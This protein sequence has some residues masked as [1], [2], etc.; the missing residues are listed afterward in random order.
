MPNPRILIINSCGKAKSVKHYNQPTCADLQ[1]QEQR[2]AAVNKFA[3]FLR[4]A[5]DLYIGPQARAVKEAVGILSKSHE[6]VYY[7]IS[8]GFGLV[9]ADTLLPPYECSFSGLGKKEILER[10]MQLDIP[11]KI[12]ELLV[13]S[14]HFDIIFL[15]LGKD[16]IT[17][18]GNLT[19]FTAFADKIIIFTHIKDINSRKF[20]IY[21]P[22]LFV[23]N[24]L[25]KQIFDVP[26]GPTV[27]AKGTILLNYAK[28]LVHRGQTV[29]EYTFS[30]WWNEKEAKLSETKGKL[31]EISPTAAVTASVESFLY[32]KKVNNFI[33]SKPYNRRDDY[34]VSEGAS[35]FI[36]KRMA[37]KFSD[38]EVKELWER[39]KN[40]RSINT[41]SGESRRAYVNLYKDSHSFFKKVRDKV[42]EITNETKEKYPEDSLSNIRGEIAN[43]LRI[44]QEKLGYENRLFNAVKYAM[45]KS[46]VGM[47]EDPRKLDMPVVYKPRKAKG[48]KK[49]A[50]LIKQEEID[51]VIESKTKKSDSWEVLAIVENRTHYPLQNIRIELLDKKGKTIP[52]TAA[53]GRLVELAQ[54]KIFIPIVEAPMDDE[55]S[56]TRILFRTSIVEPLDKGAIARIELDD[57]VNKE[58]VD[59]EFEI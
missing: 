15:T 41:R 37:E 23:E 19:V 28:S 1:T 16:Y 46:L 25:S 5:K 33:N 17:A 6:V 38:A 51:L 26:I 21:N 8:A 30:Q 42:E 57:T 48:E 29:I 53:S 34:M 22:Q 56:E 43:Q 4:P 45:L 10:A 18:L 47:V 58:S 20:E 31:H 11:N 7:I 39:C 55:V 32:E 36:S 44:R 35:K 24:P 40:L 27:G 50:P 49:K 9:H 13:S 54:G 12:K 52:I 2:N 59:F 3:S 14:G